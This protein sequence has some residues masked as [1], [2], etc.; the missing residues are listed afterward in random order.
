MIGTIYNKTAEAC[1]WLQRLQLARALV[2]GWAGSRIPQLI[3]PWV[4]G[5]RERALNPRAAPAKPLQADRCLLFIRPLPNS[6]GRAYTCSVKNADTSSFLT[7]AESIIFPEFIKHEAAVNWR[8][9][10][11]AG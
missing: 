1:G 4:R 10:T 7:A 2:A 9:L 11:G 8:P 5:P 6:C 3:S